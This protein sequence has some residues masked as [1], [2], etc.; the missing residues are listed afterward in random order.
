MLF[1]G[2]RIWYEGT[3]ADLNSLTEEI[4]SS[5]FTGHI[6]LEFQ[7]SIDIVVCIGGEFHKVIEKVGRRLLSTKKYREI[8]G[9]CQIKAGRML[10]FEL[11]PALGRRLRA[12]HARR[13]LCSGTA[14]T[15]CDPE[16]LLRD[17]KAAG[18]SGLMDCVSPEGKLLLDLDAGV[19]TGC[20]YSEYEGLSYR[21]LEAFKVWHRG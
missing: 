21:D 20:W 12:L 2:S 9:K 5:G 10:V 17:L 4:K 16:R 7:D 18:F 13:L 15:G 19:I 8:W 14:A 6:V 1:P 11:P 3:A